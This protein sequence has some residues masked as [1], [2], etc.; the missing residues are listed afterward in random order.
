MMW[1]WLLVVDNVEAT[2]LGSLA[3]ADHLGKL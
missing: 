3:A 2:L 1:W